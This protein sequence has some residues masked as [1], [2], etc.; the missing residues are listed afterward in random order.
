MLDCA[1]PFN[2]LRICC[3]SGLHCREME[4]SSNE[5]N[6]HH[7]RSDGCGLTRKEKGGR[8]ALWDFFLIEDNRSKK[9]AQWF[10][11]TNAS[12]QLIIDAWRDKVLE[13]RPQ[14]FFSA[15][16][17]K[18]RAIN[19]PR[20]RRKPPGHPRAWDWLQQI[21]RGDGDRGGLMVQNL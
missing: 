3:S 2:R 5:V 21:L 20:R 10:L 12:F 18:I 15:C 8:S 14:F 19:I 13:S 9:E 17:R 6:S 1:L 11:R 7:C 4:Y 16:D